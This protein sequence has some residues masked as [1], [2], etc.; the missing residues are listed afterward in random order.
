M[1]TTAIEAAIVS[2]SLLIGAA[3]ARAETG[4]ATDALPANAP[5]QTNADV[6]ANSGALSSES[7]QANIPAQAT[8][9][10]GSPTTRPSKAALMARIN[11]LENKIDALQTKEEQTQADT[12]AAIQQVLADADS[13]SQLMSIG[14][15]QSGYDPNVGF[16]LQSADGNFTMHPGA[17]FQFRYEGNY[18]TGIAP[19]TGGE[20]GGRHD[21]TQDGFE[22]SRMRLR[23]DGNLFS[24]DLTY[25][26][27][28]NADQGSAVSLL[29]A[30]ATYRVSTQSPLAI[31][32]G[33]FKDPVFH[34]KNLLP[35]NQMA[36][37]RSLLDQFVGGGETQR[38]QG[39]AVIYD[40]DR[41]RGEGAFHDG[42]NSGNTKFFD[43]GGLGAGLGAGAGVAPTNFGISGRVE[44][45]VIGDRTPTFNPYSEY[46]QFTAMGA[47]QNILVVGG[48][49]DYSESGS[50]KVIFHTVDAQYDTTCGLSLYAAYEGAYRNINANKGVPLGSYYDS[51]FIVQAAYMATSRIEPFARYDYTHLDGNANPGIGQDNVHEIT[52]GANYY[53]YGQRAKVTI[54]GSWLP[55]GSPTD[56]DNLGVL[57]DD[58]HNE[59][60]LRAQFQLEM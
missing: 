60:T 54:D 35:E 36:V 5:M 13:H 4:A 58:G 29:D 47:K 21:D 31:K 45:L 19:G 43:A 1:K 40:Q 37:D 51:G 17:L 8:S 10:M 48:G 23:L 20:T 55:D 50:D 53:L 12:T 59:F 22:V 32:V 26:F 33:Q 30:Y 9:A 25:Y 34:E 57:R 46:D 7:A 11:A 38:V 49:F 18:R 16:V 42:F 3:A 14:S 28:V 44:Y 15:Y 41:L 56:V 27:Q 6:Q 52:I 24:P 2:V 39:V